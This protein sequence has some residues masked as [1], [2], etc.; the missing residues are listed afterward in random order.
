MATNTAQAVSLETVGKVVPA[1]GKPHRWK[2][3][4]A[5]GVDQV[6]LRDGK[7]LR[8]LA[9]LDEKLWVAVAMPVKGVNFD[10]KTLAALDADG[11]GRIRLPEV[12]QAIA[13]LDTTL[14]SL[15][16]LLER[17]D[18]LA[19]DSIADTAVASG[20][21]RI[22]A[23]LGKADAKTISVADVADTAK[24]FAE[25]RFNGD[26]IVPA[27]ATD[28][29]PTKQAIEDIMSCFGS[30]PDR[31]GKPGIDRPRL[32]SFFNDVRAISAWQARADTA[33][34]PL[35]PAT[36]AAAA[37]FTQVAPKIE[38]YFVRCRL[39]AFDAR[40]AT[41]LSGSDADLAALAPLE[42][43][44]A[45][46]PLRKLPLARIEPSRALPLVSGLNPAWAAEMKTFAR[47]CVTPLV[48]EKQA[49]TPE[50][51]ETLKTKLSP[52][53][54]WLGEKPATTVE[55]LGLERVAVVAA[56]DSEAKIGGL[57]LQDLALE[58]ESA[59]IASVE[60]LL[61]LR[62]DLVDV[63]HNFVNFSD[64]YAHKGAAFQSGTLILDGRSCRLCLEVS[65]VGRH[66]ALAPMAGAFLAYCECTRPGGEKMTIA[67]AFTDGDSDHL[68]VGRNGIF[69]D[70]KGRDWDATISKIVS[71]PISIREA[72][73]SPYKKL[74]RLIEE[75]VGKRAA[76]ADA[77]STARMG[78]TAKDVA[79]ADKDKDP[80]KQQPEETKIDVGT[81]A[82]I[83]VAIGGIGAMFT[84]VLTAFFG[85]GLWMPLGIIA[86]LLGI[87]G[88]SML[89]A[90][91]KL[92]Q[93]NLGPLLDANGWAIN[94]RARI[95]V[96]FGGALTDVA[97]LPRNAE[98][99]MKDPYAEKKKPWGLYFT[100]VLLIVLAATWYTGRLDK[101]L[102]ESVRAATVL[103]R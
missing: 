45:P 59:Q 102:P 8:A 92:R 55:K 31:S 50:D 68:I 53:L 84:G 100:L 27:D 5:G 6:Q 49:L 26:G 37:A 36:A 51:F 96:P 40:A 72:F 86:V 54:A 10:A 71:N 38:D 24:V 75:Q 91:L 30:A 9:S 4:R 34:L 67:A 74:A 13:W 14:K 23:N 3:Y 70:R 35:G 65:D 19:I 88:P 76:A 97:K 95:N 103:H 57:L 80:K 28:D 64:F 52:H 87:S 1:N 12:L 56:S 41:A 48:G 25:T 44:A 22:L 85:L 18:D 61:L 29:A 11:D 58:Q 98:R 93:R 60:K 33:I 62:R 15:D 46:E 77:E 94:G 101:H 69:F 2:F 81:V 90:Y 16:L 21:R 17:G 39:A 42:L 89:L 78:S 82:A 32:E 43:G 20:A 79:E 66:A 63:L 73:W 47:D 7:D 99:S 83:G